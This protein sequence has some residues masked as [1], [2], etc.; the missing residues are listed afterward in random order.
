MKKEKDISGQRFNHLVAKKRAF[1]KKGI[2]FWVFACDCG[3]TKN[4]PKQSVIRGVI[5]SCGCK[6]GEYIAIRN[7]KGGNRKTEEEKRLGDVYAAMKDRCM[8]IKN[9]RYKR[10]G[11]RGITICNLWSGT[12]GR[13]NFIEWGKSSGYK[14]GLTIERINND[15]GYCPENCKWATKYEQNRN[16]IQNNNIEIDGIKMCISDIA[17]KYGINRMTLYYRLKRGLDIKNAL[18]LKK[19]KQMKG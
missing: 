14:K 5:K 1:S 11:G 4:I 7:R 10:Y 18:T 8:N 12:N 15:K 16:T 2:I 13:K 19:Y 9:K 17:K 3:K 6:R